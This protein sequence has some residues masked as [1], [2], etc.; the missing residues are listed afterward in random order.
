MAQF[1]QSE[2]RS[3]SGACFPQSGNNI[4]GQ[5]VIKVTRDSKPIDELSIPNS[6][7]VW[8]GGEF[9]LY[10]NEYSISK[11]LGFDTYVYNYSQIKDAYT[12]STIKGGVENVPLR[13]KAGYKTAWEYVLATIEPNNVST[14]P[15]WYATNTDGSAPDTDYK[16]FLSVAA[17]AEDW[18]LVNGGS[19]LWKN[20]ERTFRDYR[21]VVSETSYLD[22]PDIADIRATR[23]GMT[24]RPINTHGLPEDNKHWLITSTN[25]ALEGGFF[26]LTV[27]Y[28]YKY[29]L[30]KDNVEQGWDEDI[31]L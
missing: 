24:E 14:L 4:K 28:E 7:D 21:I 26:V 17:M 30:D 16:W 12:R 15:D 10:F 23:V 8:P 2:S 29:Y 13:Q 6:G 1:E 25:T 11:G 5:R 19:D 31:Y 22:N 18:Y 20:G 27:I 9:E 3:V